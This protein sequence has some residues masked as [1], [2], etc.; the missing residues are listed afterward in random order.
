MSAD[1]ERAIRRLAAFCG[2]PL[3]AALLALTLER[4][5]LGYM[6]RHKDRFDDAMMRR[7]SETA[8]GLPPGSDSAKVR[9][10]AVGSH[11]D[12]LPA[13]IAAAIEA[14]WRERVTPQLGFE[15]YA[16]LAAALPA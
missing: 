2:I 11:R 6:L 3:D 1:P 9:R 5:S 14:R 10:G 13:E 15:S 8:C 7:L 12:E 4:S 16:A